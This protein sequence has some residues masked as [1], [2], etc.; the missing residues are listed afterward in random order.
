MANLSATIAAL[1]SML[2]SQ[3]RRLQTDVTASL[4][5][6]DLGLR[7]RSRKDLDKFR[8]RQ[9]ADTEKKTS[10]MERQ[11]RDSRQGLKA[12]AFHENKKE[13]QDVITMEKVDFAND[14]WST[15]FSATYDKIVGG[16]T[17]IDKSHHKNM[18]NFLAGDPVKNKHFMWAAFNAGMAPNPTEQST[19]GLQNLHN[20][21]VFYGKAKKLYGMQRDL[22]REVEELSFVSK[23]GTEEERYEEENRIKYDWDRATIAGMK[24]YSDAEHTSDTNEGI[25]SSALTPVLK[26]IRTSTYNEITETDVAKK[27][28][29]KMIAMR[30]AGDFSYRETQ[31]FLDLNPYFQGSYD[32]KGKITG[33]NVHRMTGKGFTQPSGA[34]DYDLGTD[35]RLKWT[36]QEQFDFQEGV[37]DDINAQ[38]HDARSVITKMNDDMALMTENAARSG[39]TTMPAEYNNMQVTRFKEEERLAFLEQHQ[40]E[41][42]QQVA[43]RTMG[44]QDDWWGTG[45]NLRNRLP[46]EHI[47]KTERESRVRDKKA[48]TLIGSGVGLGGVNMGGVYSLWDNVQESVKAEDVGKPTPQVNDPNS[49]TN[50]MKRGVSNMG[51]GLLTTMDLLSFKPPYRQ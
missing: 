11:Q 5:A 50:T 15:M 13:I 1:N 12:K 30:E 38:I 36:E 14:I 18:Y 26:N 9:M 20:N 7:E 27:E 48:Q 39:V 46:A 21:K 19:S 49:F 42:Y 2:A 47:T 29:D 37:M 17:K 31:T 24:D 41:S 3:E 45:K 40:M 33:V 51:Q 8:T 23:L 28:M 32:S 4:S 6:M 16:T 35:E 25:G 22:D 10:I 44:S 34:F 43:D